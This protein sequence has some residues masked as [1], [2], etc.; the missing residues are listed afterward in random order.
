MSIENRRQL[1]NTRTKLRELGEQ[2]ARTAQAPPKDLHVR[3]LTLRSLKK[4]MNRL[5]EE[6][7]RFES[8]VIHTT[9]KG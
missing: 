1:E 7:A 9:G 4:R 2:Y 8:R 5:T 3:E 6:I